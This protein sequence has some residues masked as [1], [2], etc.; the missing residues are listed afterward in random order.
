MVGLVGLGARVSHV[1]VLL[2]SVV[3]CV[4]RLESVRLEGLIKRV[5]LEG[6]LNEDNL[7]NFWLSLLCMVL[8]LA[9]STEESL[10][11]AWSVCSCGSAG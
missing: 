10:E 4:K 9:K 11:W 8:L 1:I 3:N 7:Y 5:R 6:L 2:V